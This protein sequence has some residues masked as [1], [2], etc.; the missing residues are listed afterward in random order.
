MV[1]LKNVSLL[2]ISCDGTP[3]AIFLLNPFRY[4]KLYVRHY[5]SPYIY[6]KYN[7]LAQE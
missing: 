5:L 2:F 6:L 7:G 1:L 4:S 3:Y